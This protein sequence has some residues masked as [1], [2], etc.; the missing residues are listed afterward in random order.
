MTRVW[1]WVSLLTLIITCASGALADVEK[2]YDETRL[3]YFQTDSINVEFLNNSWNIPT[4]YFKDGKTIGQMV[5]DGFDVVDA[6]IDTANPEDAPSDALNDLLGEL[7]INEEI[8]IPF[9]DVTIPGE[10]LTIIPK[11]VFFGETI[12]KAVKIDTSVHIEFKTG[13]TLNEVTGTDKLVRVVLENDGLKFN[14]QVEAIP[15]GTNELIDPANWQQAIGRPR[16]K[17]LRVSVVNGTAT[18]LEAGEDWPILTAPDEWP[19]DE[20]R[21]TNWQNRDWA[22]EVSWVTD[23]K[24][25]KKAVLRTHDV[26]G[27]TGD[28]SSRFY[29]VTDYDEAT[30]KLTIDL[31]KPEDGYPLTF[32]AGGSGISLSAPLLDYTGTIFGLGLTKH[33]SDAD[34]RIIAD[35]SAPKLGL[36]REPMP[37]SG[38]WILDYKLDVGNVNWSAIAAEQPNPNISFTFHSKIQGKFLGIPIDIDLLAP[39]DPF[40]LNLL[41]DI[42]IPVPAAAFSGTYQFY[43]D[44]TRATNQTRFSGVNEINWRALGFPTVNELCGGDTACQAVMTENMFDLVIDSLPPLI[45]CL[46][47]PGFSF[48]CYSNSEVIEEVFGNTFSFPTVTLETILL[49]NNELLDD[50]LND[51]LADKAVPLMINAANDTLWKAAFPAQTE[52]FWIMDGINALFD[53]IARRAAERATPVPALGFSGILTATALLAMVGF[54]K[55]GASRARNRVL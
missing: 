20:V 10:E 36:P 12:W 43:M 40:Q 31:E 39:L 48:P 53:P 19:I 37:E 18:L 52:K 25:L 11:F 22:A 32:E 21:F 28:P 30:G 2:P 42:V 8:N 1:L 4:D 29:Q 35:L 17:D 55:L 44:P 9:D 38:Q 49:A 24:K 47:I 5:I 6:V 13:V 41:E 16:L 33:G 14:R 54:K 51:A 27:P 15:A 50:A 46:K 34:E 3:D 7:V 26:T 45:T 23:P